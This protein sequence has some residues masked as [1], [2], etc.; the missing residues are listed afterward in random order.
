[1]NIRCAFC[2]TPYAIGRNEMLAALQHMQAENLNHYD[3][4]CPR[5]RRATN[6]PRQRMEIFLP[7]WRDALKELEVEM[8]AHPQQPAPA[9]KPEPVLVEQAESK[10]APALVKEKPEARKETI[11]KPAAASS[12]RS[13]QGGKGKAKTAS[14]PAAKAKAPAMTKSK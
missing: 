10:P 1:M 14:K 3:A 12:P 9:S 2:Q 8:A 6:I 4:H 11:K 5:C 7:N 13:R